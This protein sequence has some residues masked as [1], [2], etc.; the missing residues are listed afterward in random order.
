LVQSDT[1]VKYQL[2][3]YGTLNFPVRFIV[4]SVIW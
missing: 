1:K 2:D 4:I 3:T